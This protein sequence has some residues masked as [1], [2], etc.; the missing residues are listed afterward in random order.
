M[1]CARS[2]DSMLALCSRT[3]VLQESMRDYLSFA[4]TTNP[5]ARVTVISASFPSARMERIL[6]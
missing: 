6:L 5:V 4:P 2:Q 3:L 1:T